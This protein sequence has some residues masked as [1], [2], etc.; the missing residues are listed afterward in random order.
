MIKQV[1]HTATGVGAA[2]F[3]LALEVAGVLHTPAAPSRAPELATAPLNA[4]R[5]AA[6]AR[7]RRRTV[8]G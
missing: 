6:A 1:E 3:A 4:G 5:R 8:R 7:A 2:D